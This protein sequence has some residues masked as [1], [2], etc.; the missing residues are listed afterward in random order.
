[1]PKSRGRQA[2]SRKTES[3]SPSKTESRLLS[4]REVL[5]STPG[6]I[7]T[8]IA[9]VSLVWT[10]SDHVYQTYLSTRP[11]IHVSGQDASAFSLPFSVKNNSSIF[12]MYQAEWKCGIRKVQLGQLIIQDLSVTYSAAKASIP[13]GGTAYFR[14]NVTDL[15]PDT[16]VIVPFISYKTLGFPRVYEDAVFT[17]LPQAKPPRWIEGEYPQ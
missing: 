11:E 16:A 13:P 8:L 12:T 5:R 10:F 4:W 2:T 15:T 3:R 14:C 17:W 7:L 9:A 1:M 6:R